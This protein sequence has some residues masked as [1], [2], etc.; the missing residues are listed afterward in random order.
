MDY[1][2]NHISTP[3]LDNNTR[4]SSGT[5][6]EDNLSLYWR[7][8]PALRYGIDFVVTMFGL[9]VHLGGALG[10]LGSITSVTGR[11]DDHSNQIS[12]SFS[13]KGG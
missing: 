12:L 11:I 10:A 4:V 9:D 6:L 2:S 13:M 8:T 3:E 5:A 7:S 1:S